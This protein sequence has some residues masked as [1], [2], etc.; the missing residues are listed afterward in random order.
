MVH[1]TS[2]RSFL[3]LTFSLQVA[4][5]SAVVPAGYYYFAKNKMKADLKTALHTYCTPMQMLE[6]GGGKGYTWEGFYYTDRN[7][8]NSVVD[9]YSSNIRSFTG[10]AAVDGMHIEHSFPK[11]WW[12]AY[13]NN[14]YKDLFHLYP[15]DAS[16][17][18]SKNNLPLGEV[19]GTPSMTNGVSKVGV[20]GF[21]TTYTDKCFEPADE[22][23]GDFARSYFYISTVY[24]NLAPLI[25]SPMVINNNTYPFWKPWAIDLLLKWHHQDP[26]SDRERT[27]IETVYSIQGNRNPFIDYPLLADYIWGA[28]STKVFPFPEET[29]PFLLTPRRGTTLDLGVIHKND[30]RASVVHLQG[31]HINT[32]IQV[33]LKQNNPSLALSTSSLSVQQALDGVD[34]TVTFTALAAGIVRDTILIQGGGLA[35]SITLPVRA[36]ASTDFIA[37]DPTDVTPVGG[38]LKWIS[39]PDATDYSLKVYEH[40]DKAGDLI[41]SAYVEGSSWNKALEI[42]NGT[43]KT[44]DLSN[45]SIQKQ[46]NGSGDYGY[47]IRLTG[48][49]PASASYKLVNSHCTTAGLTALATKLDSLI[50]YNGNDA[51]VLTRGGVIV[52]QVGNANAGAADMWGENVSL[53]RNSSVTHPS[54]VYNAT[55]WTKSPIDTYTML[56]NHQMTFT[57]GGPVL[58]EDVLTGKNTEHA[59]EN[60]IPQSTYTYSVEAIK[61]SGTTMTVNTM[62][63]HTSALDA[64]E[65]SEASDVRDI[66][67]TANWGVSAYANGY[68]LDVYTI[69]GATDTTVTEGFD[70]VG[71]TGTPLP[72]GWT[73]TASGNY[74]TTTS[75]GVA[76]PS[77]ALKVKG[78]WLQTK[79]YPLPVSRLTFMYRFPTATTTSSLI[80]EGLSNNV[81]TGVD[82][83]QCV[84]TSKYYP[85]YNLDKA[86]MFTAFRWRFN[87]EG[88]GNLSIDDVSATYGSQE[89]VYVQKDVPVTGNQTVV[90]GLTKNSEYYY[91]TRATLKGAVSSSSDAMRVKTLLSN[92]L[93]DAPAGNLKIYSQ[94]EAV[95]IQGLQGNEIVRIYSI[96]GNCLFQQQVTETAISIPFH[97][98]GMY[99][100][101]VKNNAYS[102][103]TKIVK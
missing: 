3:L 94:K 49:L 101:Q 63:L 46:S 75:G 22:F 78:E 50:N 12:G 54:S 51:V 14:A 66:Q 60:L 76:P 29:E 25:Q 64:P 86:G 6:Y 96:T 68:L 37:I 34:V 82:S 95:R 97:Q 93:D 5:L 30:T 91:T 70:A 1:S 41:I 79:T 71:T 103:G 20:N 7:A 26:V 90:T 9:R 83:I 42:Y 45:Y 55:E 102:Y 15:A 52:D 2:K 28:D 44:V 87:K 88:S 85:V 32:S 21:E 89:K 61:P 73:G 72:V 16:A 13:E 57:A 35:E 65:I 39:E 81:W 47:D 77:M 10:F 53:Q 8:D 11:S 31:V 48:T 23:K 99:L 4:F 84:N 19:A 58:I 74:T 100:L 27:R 80:V 17:N 98:K 43:G 56:G 36:L 62:Q 69:H 92:K 24:E 18:E 38:K 67:F 33:S 40:E 59:I